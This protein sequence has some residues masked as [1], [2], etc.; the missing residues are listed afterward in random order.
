MLIGTWNREA[1]KSGLKFGGLFTWNCYCRERSKF[2]FNLI[3]VRD[4][5]CE[6]FFQL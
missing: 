2:P 1:I 5:A 4:A 6:G 3:R